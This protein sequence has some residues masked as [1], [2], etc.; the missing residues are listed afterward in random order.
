MFYRLMNELS[1]FMGAKTT[2]IEPIL[3]VNVREVGGLFFLFNHILLGLD[4][5]C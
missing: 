4:D 1:L 5:C 3:N 2:L